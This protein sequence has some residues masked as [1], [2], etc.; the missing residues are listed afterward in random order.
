MTPR[1]GETS[2]AVPSHSTCTYWHAPTTD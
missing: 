2:P 1:R